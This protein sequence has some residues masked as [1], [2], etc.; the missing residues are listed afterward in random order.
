[1]NSITLRRKSWF[2]QQINF[3]GQRGRDGGESGAVE[4][5][6]RLQMGDRPGLPPTAIQRAQG[7][8]QQ[9]ASE[10]HCLARSSRRHVEMSADEM[11]ASKG[12]R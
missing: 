1:M 8:P 5:L 12:F 6:G 2:R 11:K 10:Q 9:A 4:G 3:K 7:R